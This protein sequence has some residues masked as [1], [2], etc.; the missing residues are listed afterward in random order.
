MLDMLSERDHTIMSLWHDLLNNKEYMTRDG[1]YY[2]A[3]ALLID[4]CLTQQRA[5][6]SLDDE[7]QRLREMVAQMYPRAKA[8]LQIGVQM[9][10]NDTLSYDWEQQMRELGIEVGK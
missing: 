5:I 4:K 7:N 3:D 6:C 10:C 2:V 9:G 8:F 1:K